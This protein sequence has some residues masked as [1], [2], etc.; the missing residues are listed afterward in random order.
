MQAELQDER[1]ECPCC[2]RLL[3]D[4]SELETYRNALKFLGSENSPLIKTDG[5]IIEARGKYKEW[6]AIIKDISNDVLEYLRLKVELEEVERHAKELDLHLVDSKRE[7]VDA[8]EIVTS[9]QGETND[10]KDFFD[11]SK[12]WVDTS[13]RIAMQREQV[14]QKEYDSRH[15]T[16]DRDGRDL[17]QVDK[18]LEDLSQK[19]D[20]FADKKN[21]LNTEMS[22]INDRVASF[23]QTATRLE[24]QLRNMEAKYE[25]EYVFTSWVEPVFQRR[26]VF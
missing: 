21:Q 18:D 14:N 23:S 8:Q 24:T 3:I 4:D 26:I 11:A 7:L 16:G 1:Y 13:V 2:K 12:R 20:E 25:E 15:M 6:C 22:A 10:A 9:I 17:K 5:K 19:K